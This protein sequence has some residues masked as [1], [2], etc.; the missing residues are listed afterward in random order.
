MMQPQ[1]RTHQRRVSANP[2]PYGTS[3]THLFLRLL[4][5]AACP[6]ESKFAAAGNDGSVTLFS[7][8]LEPLHC[9]FGDRCASR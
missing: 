2:L 1:D 4:R 5:Q 8:H 7:M 6:D 3:V 9:A